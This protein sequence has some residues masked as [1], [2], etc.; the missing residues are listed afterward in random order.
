MRDVDR[1]AHPSEERVNLLFHL[2]GKKTKQQREGDSKE[3]IT[4]SLNAGEIFS[5]RG[6]P[7]NLMR[8]QEKLTVQAQLQQGREK[9]GPNGGGTAYTACRACGRPLADPK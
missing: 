1:V 9:V 8:A 4:E 7:T 6:L 2:R 3:E 5:G